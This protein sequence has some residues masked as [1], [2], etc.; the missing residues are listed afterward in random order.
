MQAKTTILVLLMTSIA[1]AQTGAPSPAECEKKN[2]AYYKGETIETCLPKGPA[3][4]IE[5][6]IKLGAN[7]T[8]IESEI[9]RATDNSGGGKIKG[10]VKIKAVPIDV[11][12]GAA[13]RFSEQFE[14]KKKELLGPMPFASCKAMADAVSPPPVAPRAANTGGGLRVVAATL[15]LGK[16]DEEAPPIVKYTLKNDS[17]RSQVIAKFE[18]RVTG[19][20]PYAS[21]PETRPLASLAVWD[22]LLPVSSGAT[23][24]LNGDPPVIVA[25]DDAATISLR[26]SS[27]RPGMSARKSGRYTVVTTFISD[28][29]TRAVAEAKT[30]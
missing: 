25:K 30:F 27:Y 23:L 26:F 1:A 22:V 12:A 10:G 8:S 18:V 17:S 3:L 29:G 2:L 6:G 9:K 24:S 7:R 13:L 4:F 15:D 16:E 11:A 28:N 5:C 20:L 19:Y 14:V 21:A